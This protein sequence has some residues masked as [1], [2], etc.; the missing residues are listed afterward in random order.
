MGK[1]IAGDHAFNRVLEALARVGT[2]PTQRFGWLVQVAERDLTDTSVVETTRAEMSAFSLS[3]TVAAQPTEG[4]LFVRALTNAP[5]LSGRRASHATR[6]LQRWLRGTLDHLRDERRFVG[7]VT[8]GSAVW[9]ETGA[10]VPV[11]AGDDG[12]RFRFAVFGLLLHVAPRIHVCPSSDC[13]RLFM[14]AGKQA[15]CSKRCSQH[16]RTARFRSA[17]LDKVRGSRRSA[18]EQRL[19][20][21]LGPNVRIG[22]R[23]SKARA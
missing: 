22:R 13:R 2:E 12:Q 23:P 11:A 3:G 9:T 5:S 7:P 16:A 17:H 20:A 19:R 8:I 15:Y 14:K 6:E 4:E 1:R 18:Y 10:L 21:K